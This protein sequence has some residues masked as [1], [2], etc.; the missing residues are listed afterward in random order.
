MTIASENV[1]LVTY[2]AEDDCFQEFLA[3]EHYSIDRLLITRVVY[4]LLWIGAFFQEWCGMV[5]CVDTFMV[6]GME[7]EWSTCEV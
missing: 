3:L 7:H 5:G 1:I 2:V 6:V 4:E